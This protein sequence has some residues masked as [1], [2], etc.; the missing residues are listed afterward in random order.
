MARLVGLCIR[1]ICRTLEA[2]PMTGR[3]ITAITGLD[4]EQVGKYCSRGVGLGLLKVKRGTR[5]TANPDVFSV[6]P[7]WLEMADQRKTTRL[8]PLKPPKPKPTKWTGVNSVIG[9]A[10]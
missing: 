6:V 5:T 9:M 7:N 3:E 1:R 8:K 10:A 4:R 2:G